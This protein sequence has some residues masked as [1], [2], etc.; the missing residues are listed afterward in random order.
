[1]QPAP[2]PTDTWL[3]EPQESK[4]SSV[5]PIVIKIV[6]RF[7]HCM[8]VIDLSLRV[9]AIDFFHFLYLVECSCLLCGPRLL[10]E[11]R[12]RRPLE[13]ARTKVIVKVAGGLISIYRIYFHLFFAKNSTLSTLLYL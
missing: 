12:N 11:A 8:F 3:D 4:Q 2:A 5:G 6:S 13:D 7:I 9:F 1:V 10:L